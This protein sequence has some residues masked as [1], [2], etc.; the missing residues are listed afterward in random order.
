MQRMRTAWVVAVLAAGCASKPPQA[1]GP[2]AAAGVTYRVERQTCAPCN[3][4]RLA[5]ERV[6][7]SAVDCGTVA[8]A[9]DAGKVLQ[10]IAEAKASRR[11]FRAA[12][13]GQGK[14]RVMA[15]IFLGSAEGDELALRYQGGAASPS[16]ACSGAVTE[17]VC[18]AI[19]AVP[20]TG[21]RCDGPAVAQSLC[22]ESVARGRTLGPERPV[23]ELTCQGDLE[24]HN[25]EPVARVACR[26]TTVI[27]KEQLTRSV[28]CSA[29]LRD[30][31]E[32]I[33]FERSGWE[34]DDTLSGAH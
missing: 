3:L 11:G 16:L 4:D 20:G 6:A 7:R 22:D 18:S 24:H 9:E 15:T 27:A 13:A 12:E 33:C 23:S 1:A 21:L 8:G 28:I 10:C 26:R 19:T 32:L 14:D 5:A 34:A 31:E 29:L 2:G 25:A 17:K 30:P